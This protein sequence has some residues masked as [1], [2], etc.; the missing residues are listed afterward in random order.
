MIQ[1]IGLSK[2]PASLEQ[3][4]KDIREQSERNELARLQAKYPKDKR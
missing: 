2:M 4:V 1:A 3:L